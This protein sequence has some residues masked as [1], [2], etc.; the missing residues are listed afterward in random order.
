MGDIIKFPQGGKSKNPATQDILIGVANAILKEICA[1]HIDHRV[2]PGRI[3]GWLVVV[4]QFLLEGQGLPRFVT[5]AQEAQLIRMYSEVWR[6]V[7]SERL[8]SK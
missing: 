3:S 5:P 6:E 2:E 8:T 7:L 4:E 1:A